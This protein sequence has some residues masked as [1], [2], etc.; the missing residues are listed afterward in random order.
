MSVPDPSAIVQSELQIRTLL[1]EIAQLSKSDIPPDEF[2]AE[3]L[4]RVV[5]AL[6]AVGGAL[7]IL[8][9]NALALAYQIN[10]RE[11]R[12]SDGDAKHTRLLHRLL[13][14]PD[15]GTLLPPHSGTEG[16]QDIG[17]LTDYLYLDRL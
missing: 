7:W 5:S 2:H 1:G 15:T 13:H 4:R 3:F 9:G 16:D 10:F 17:N 11:L 14:S 8:D 6:G 12:L